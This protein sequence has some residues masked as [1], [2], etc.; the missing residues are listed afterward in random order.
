[1]IGQI[2]GRPR[3]LEKMRKSVVSGHVLDIEGHSE[4]EPQLDRVVG[5][6][7]SG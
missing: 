4:I 1:M 6:E 2:F 3:T 7:P 5:N